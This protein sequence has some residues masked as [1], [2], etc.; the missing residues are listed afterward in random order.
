ML[1]ITGELGRVEEFLSEVVYP[2]WPLWL[3][4]ALIALG[5][6]GYFA[7]RL[8]L[9]TWAMRHRVM[10]GAA[11]AI[12][13]VVAVP[14]SYYTISP[15]FDRE[16]VCEASPIAGMGSGS[17]DCED[18]AAATMTTRRWH[19]PRQRLPPQRPVAKR[20]RNSSSLMVGTRIRRSAITT[21]G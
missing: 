5:A 2:A 13:L 12:L 10:T 9:H 11:A 17:E 18:V 15:I 19:R 1:A 8:G 16:T 4:G 21:S 6:A 20:P 14:L 3:A 7:Y